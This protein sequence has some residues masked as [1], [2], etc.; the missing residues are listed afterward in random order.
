M[1]TRLSCHVVAGFPLTNNN[2]EHSV[3]FLKQRFWQS[4]KLINVHM[5][6]LLILTKP[7]NNYSSLQTF[8]DTIENHMKTLSSLGKSSDAYD[9][10]QTPI[11]PNTLPNEIQKTLVRKN[12]AHQIHLQSGVQQTRNTALK[13]HE[14]LHE[15]SKLLRTPRRMLRSEQLQLQS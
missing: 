8:Y 3:F 2:Y 14:K 13:A 9:S 6:I 10:L 12:S 1:I 11:I 4:Y 7:A 5:Q 15:W